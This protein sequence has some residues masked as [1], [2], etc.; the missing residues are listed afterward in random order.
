MG[1]LSVTDHNKGEP[2]FAIELWIGGKQL[3][4]NNFPTHLTVNTHYLLF[5]IHILLCRSILAV[6]E[7]NR[8]WKLY[9]DYIALD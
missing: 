4:E 8:N 6:Q 3:K 1:A 5:L 2:F 7:N 9:E